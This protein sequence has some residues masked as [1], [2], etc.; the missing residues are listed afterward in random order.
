MTTRTGEIGMGEAPIAEADARRL[1]WLARLVAVLTATMI[2]GVVTIAALL[3][4]RL[5]TTP[6]LPLPGEI[7]LP[8]G[9][10][11]VSVTVGPEWYAVGTED[12]RLLVF[13]REGGALL[14]EVLIE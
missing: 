3:V 5:S 4:T 8:E 10:R 9:A 13:A 1:R 6:P 14:Q 7:A 2:I 11:A 12:G